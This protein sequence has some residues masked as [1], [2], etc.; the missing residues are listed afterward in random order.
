[1]YED[2]QILRDIYFCCINCQQIFTIRMEKAINKTFP[3]R[4]LTISQTYHNYYGVKN[5][6]YN[7]SDDMIK[8]LVK[9]DKI[10]KPI[11]K[12]YYG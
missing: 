9:D 1:M 10:C 7:W 4:I 6:S 12:N 11:T 2:Y 5:I 3:D 8:C